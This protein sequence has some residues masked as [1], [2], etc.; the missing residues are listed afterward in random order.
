MFAVHIGRAS[1]T[2]GG[3]MVDG[4]GRE[5]GVSMVT[6]VTEGKGGLASHLSLRKRKLRQDSQQPQY[7]R[8]RRA[9]C[10]WVSLSWLWADNPGLSEALSISIRKALC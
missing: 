1:S 7:R 8:D 10:G 3:D 5:G 2:E 4:R 6:G 9:I